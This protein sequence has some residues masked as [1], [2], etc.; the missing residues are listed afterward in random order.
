MTNTENFENEMRE[1]AKR[2]LEEKKVDLIIGYEYGTLPLRTIPC[3]IKNPEEVDRLVWN[4]FCDINLSK[5]LLN[6][7]EKIGIIGK[8]CDIRSLTALALENQINPEN[9][10]IIGLP[11]PQLIDRRKI[12]AALNGKEISEV[13][14]SNDEIV[15]KG[16]DFEETLLKKNFLHDS[17]ITCTHKNPLNCNIIIGEQIPET[18][19]QDTYDDI[20]AFEQKSSD[21][22]WE[23]IKETLSDC[24]RCYACRN[25]CPMC[26]CKECFVDATQPLWFG[27][28]TDI[29]DT[30]AYHIVRAIHTA[31]RCVG[32]GSCSR[33]CP[34]GI[35][36]RILTRKLEKSI[37][38]R[39]GF[40]VGIEPKEA[41]PMATNKQ[42][43]P[44]EFIME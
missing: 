37:K 30:I 39:F 38:E 23:Y 22:R 3:F 11:C 31:G 32:C 1:T 44:Q 18:I 12:Q 17:C 43:D 5:Y 25:I 20:A 7:K 26:Y 13:K 6:R 21:E 36:I 8:A 33:A 9:L 34:M 4:S 27:K 15:I 40:E 29:S 14:I 24:I 28:T 41:P 19:E 35:N 42:D 10:I 2:L 16:K